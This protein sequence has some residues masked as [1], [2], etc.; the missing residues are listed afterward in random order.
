MEVTPRSRTNLGEWGNY[1][2][3]RPNDVGFWDFDAEETATATATPTS[4]PES[5]DSGSSGGVETPTPS[6][7]ASDPYDCG[8]FEGYP[9]AAQQW[10]EDRNPDEDPAGLDGDDGQACE[11]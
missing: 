8:D 7:D 1:E 10:F 2:E 6:G 3:A 4:E 11:S 9:G 5:G